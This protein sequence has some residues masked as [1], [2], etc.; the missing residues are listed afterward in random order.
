LRK[1]AVEFTGRV[2]FIDPKTGEESL[3]DVGEIEGASWKR[4]LLYSLPVFLWRNTIG[5]VSKKK[6]EVHAVVQNGAG[7]D[8]KEDR[9]A[10]VLDK[11]AKAEK[12]AGKR[13]VKKKN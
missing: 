12:V 10:S 6:V 13:K 11:H 4:T 8:V 1:F 5:Q 7:G 9:K 3:L 2:Y